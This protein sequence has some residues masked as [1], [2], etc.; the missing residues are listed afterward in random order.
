[1]LESGQKMDVDDD[2]QAADLAVMFPQP[3]KG[4]TMASTLSMASVA[5]CA[6][7]FGITVFVDCDGTVVDAS[8][9]RRV[10]HV[11]HEAPTSCGIEGCSIEASMSPLRF[12]ATMVGY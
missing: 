12:V 11:L 8:N 7:V 3:G 2:A 1:M 4:R 6:S 5:V 10:G 9:I